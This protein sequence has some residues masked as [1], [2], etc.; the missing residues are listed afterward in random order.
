MPDKGGSRDF[1][2]EST[3]DTEGEGEK[4]EGKSKEEREQAGGGESGSAPLRLPCGNRR[5]T[6]M[7]RETETQ[8]E[9]G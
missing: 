7:A 4:T 8:Q 2:T 5:K 6:P 3:K 9:E 1:T